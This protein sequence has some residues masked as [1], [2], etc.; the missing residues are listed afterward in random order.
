MFHTLLVQPITNILVLFY[1]IIPYHDF[2]VAVIL[3]TVFIRLILWPL[4]SQQLHNQKKLNKIQPEVKK[5]QEKFKN[6]PMKMNQMVTELYKE[7]E[8]N[9]FSSCL[10]SLVQ[11]PIMIAL[12][13]AIQRFSN[14]DYIN[15]LD[16]TKG[17]WA[18]LYNWVSNLG[19]VR[20]TLANGFST[21]FLGIV[22]LAKPNPVIAVLAGAI[23]FVQTKMMMPKKQS[24]DDPT[25][26]T[27]NIMLY[28]F[29]LMAV[30]IGWK[31]AAALPLYWIVNS[32][33][34]V[35]Q[36]YLI[37]RHDIEVLEEGK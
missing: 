29:P 33:M 15:L 25:Q 17:L 11:L 1:S 9:P 14:P 10:P 13:Y 19:F 27:M 5:I 35:L 30:A 22:D 36:Q 28:M 37:M 31:F 16:H 18:E 34:A 23:Q 3:L 32:L 7:K 8:V 6:D 24:K 21:N 26:Q 20:D 12:F 2:G 4:Q